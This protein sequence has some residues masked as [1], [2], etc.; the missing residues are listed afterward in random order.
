M[1]VCA[2]DGK[3]MS[4]NGVLALESTTMNNAGEYVCIA[5]VPSVPGLQKK[6]SVTVTI[7]GTTHTWSRTLS[8]YKCVQVLPQCMPFFNT[9]FMRCNLSFIK[10]LSHVMYSCSG[11]LTLIFETFT[12]DLLLLKRGD[13]TKKKRTTAATVQHTLTQ[14]CPK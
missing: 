1:C 4:K 13:Y 7:S 9:T 3:Q 14:M 12:T 6:A 8:V 10:P 5:S 11:S 2:Q